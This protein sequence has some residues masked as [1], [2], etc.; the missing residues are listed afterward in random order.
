V[1]QSF[2]EASRAR[3]NLAV[4]AG[5][6]TNAT[7]WQTQMENYL[8]QIVEGRTNRPYFTP[9]RLIW[10]AGDSNAAGL[11]PALN[12]ATLLNRYAPMA[13]TE[14]KTDQYMVSHRVAV[15]VEVT[16]TRNIHRL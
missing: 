1:F 8:D 9:G 14:A 16:L 3:P 6:A 13:S 2:V 4:G 11:N 15:K 10:Y 7:G 5:L 12:A